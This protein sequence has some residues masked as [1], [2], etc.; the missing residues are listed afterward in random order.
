M[1][2]STRIRHLLGDSEH[3]IP[4]RRVAFLEA[5]RCRDHLAWGSC[6]QIDEPFSDDA[7]IDEAQTPASTNAMIWRARSCLSIYRELQALD[8]RSPSLN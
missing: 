8:L 4:T 7:V 3:P 2:Y 1:S 6:D 5:L